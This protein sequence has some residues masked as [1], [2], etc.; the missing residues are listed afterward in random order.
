MR[1][2]QL[3]VTSICA[4]T[5]LPRWWSVF[6]MHDMHLCQRA[7][8]TTLLWKPITLNLGLIYMHWS[9]MPSPYREARLHQYA[10][11]F[12]QKYCYSLAFGRL[13]KKVDS[14]IRLA[15]SARSSLMHANQNGCT[16]AASGRVLIKWS[17]NNTC[18]S[19]E[20]KVMCVR[21]S[22]GHLGI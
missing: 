22:G 10:C 17:Q 12:G 3:H 7:A 8:V 11:R 5:S 1:R 16:S 6:D 21:L 15:S 9:C 20:S 13:C 14:F 4:H 2:L 18:W 19:N